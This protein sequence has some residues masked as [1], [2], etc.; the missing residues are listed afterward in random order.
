MLT[1]MSCFFRLVD[2]LKRF[3]GRGGLGP[4]SLDIPAQRTTAIIGPSGCGKSTLLRLLIGLL[5]PDC[6]LVLVEDQRIAPQQLRAFRHRV[7]YVI[8]DGGL[9]PHLSGYENVALLGRHLGWPRNRLQARIS[10]LAA[11]VNLPMDLLQRP[12][13]QLSGGQRQR[14]ALMRALLLDP[15]A[16]LMDE[17]LG[18]LDPIIRAELQTELK[19]LFQRF[20]KTVVL[21][22]HDLAEAAYLADEAILLNEGRVV[23]RGPVTEL[24][25]RPA[26]EF[27]RR[28]VNAQRGLAETLR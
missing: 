13:Q 26:S 12:P 6:G 3:P 25:H 15:E 23:Q 22:T 28:F 21:V 18:A 8:Q 1:K 4:L 11:L 9:F 17:P 19:G 7:G 2:V 14:L 16:L 10:E 20:R 24:C 27:V 5:Q